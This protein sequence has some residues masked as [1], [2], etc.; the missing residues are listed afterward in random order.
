MK[1]LKDSRGSI[2]DPADAPVVWLSPKILFRVM[3]GKRIAFMPQEKTFPKINGREEK[4][5]IKRAANS[6]GKCRH[7]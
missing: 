1:S 3:P 7:P 2:V 5:Q 6:E 4:T